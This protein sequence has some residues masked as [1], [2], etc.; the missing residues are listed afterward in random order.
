MIWRYASKTELKLNKLFW[1]QTIPT[2]Q[3]YG[4][5]LTQSVMPFFLLF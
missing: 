4:R 3:F 5:K 2:H 1:E